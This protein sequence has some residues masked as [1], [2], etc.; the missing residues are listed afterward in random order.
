MGRILGRSYSQRGYNKL[1]ARKVETL[2]EPGRRSDGRNLYLVVDP[3]GAK[4]WVFMFR[5]K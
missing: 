3:S 4:R 1:S 2:T 5:W